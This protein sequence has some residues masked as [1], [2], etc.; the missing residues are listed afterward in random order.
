MKSTKAV[1]RT[2]TAVADASDT[3]PNYLSLFLHPAVFSTLWC[4]LAAGNLFFTTT[5]WIPTYFV[6][7]LGCTPL[8]TAT[9]MLWFTPVDVVGGFLVAGLES[10][11][12]RGGWSQ[13]F[14]RKAFQAA[15]VAGSS[16][17]LLAFAAVRTPLAAAVRACNM[18]GVLLL[19][20][21]HA[22]TPPAARPIG[23]SQGLLFCF[24]VLF[25]R[26]SSICKI[27]ASH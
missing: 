21:R 2:P 11:L 9:Y 16:V 23:T 10:A 13:L 20:L 4:K 3:A 24:G 12:L 5:Q 22:F 19:L 14:L 18:H 15:F 26:F 6:S 8:Q 1:T 7:V 17:S 27:F 25:I